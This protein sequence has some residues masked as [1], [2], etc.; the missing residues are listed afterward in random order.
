MS[1]QS[2]YAPTKV[3]TAP[4]FWVDRMMT[5]TA[6]RRPSRPI[7]SAVA[8]ARQQQR[9]WALEDRQPEHADRDASIVAP[10]LARLVD[11]HVAAS[12]HPVALMW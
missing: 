3:G 5:F 7:K 1:G 10:R 8:V 2:R 12:R 9:L 11:D 4:G 6:S